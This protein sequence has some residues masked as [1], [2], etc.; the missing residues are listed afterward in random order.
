MKQP[1][2]MQSGMKPIINNKMTSEK[3]K[4]NICNYIYDPA[5][6]DRSNGINPGTSFEEIPGYWS[7]PICGA[8][9]S[10]FVIFD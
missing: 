1:T 5:E 7:C 4:C 8:P 6:G 3:Y 10:E 9:K 2:H